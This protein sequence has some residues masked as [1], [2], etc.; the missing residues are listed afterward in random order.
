[1]GGG[2]GFQVRP[3]HVQAVHV[4]VEGGDVL[5]GHFLAG[6]AFLVGTG[7]DL[8]IHVGEVA[9]EGDVESGVA[10][11]AHQHV[12]H[13]GGAGVSDVAQVVRG[14]AADVH[15]DLAGHGRLEVFLL[16]GQGIVQLH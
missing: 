15:V 8:V 6:Q 7:D 5:F 2:A 10:Q 12:E 16:A 13:H 14:D 4:L 1:M 11:V 3:Q 9:R